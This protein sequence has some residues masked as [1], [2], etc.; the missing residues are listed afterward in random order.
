MSSDRDNEYFSDGMTE[1]ITTQLSK[2]ADLKVIARTSSM[3]YKNSKK[4]IKEIA[5][6]LGVSTILEGSVQKSGSKIKITAQ[7]IDANTQEHIWAEKYDREFKEVF[8]IQSEV[9]K[10]I[11]YQLNARMTRE[12]KKKIEKSPTE[13]PRAYEYYLQGK[14]THEKFLQTFKPEFY[15]SSKMMFEKA[16]ELDSNYAL[17]YAGLADLY[18]SY[19]Q[20]IKQ[21][22]SLL[23]LQ[24]KEI[25][26]AY[27]IAPE[28]DYV[29]S[30]RGSILQ[31]SP[32]SFEEAYKSF[33]KAYELNPNNTSTLY[34]L[35]MM[36]S[37]LGL[38]DERIILLKKAVELDPLNAT[39]FGF[40]GGA[41]VHLNRLNDGI[42]DLQ[43][44]HRLEPDM[45]YVIDRIAYAYSLQN[46]QAEANKWLEKFLQQNLSEER[47]P[48]F[49][50][51]YGQYA[52]YCYIKSGNKKGIGNIASLESISRSWHER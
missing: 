36:I 45:F 13:N 39:Y 10:E 24:E 25:N 51:E 32:D 49:N 16:I 42:K 38:I 11:A 20:Y 14:Q 28:V 23:A 44:A 35:A 37:D 30:V 6:E 41:E 9:A 50:N 15:E 12:E 52:A 46:N 18:H 8:A 5:E 4:S 7:L 47:A 27:S 29:N 17:A 43:T 19:T 26:K 40:L 31:N 3:L 2:I 34:A 22:S 21:D 33:R 1:E 48:N